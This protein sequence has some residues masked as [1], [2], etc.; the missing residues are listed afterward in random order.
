MTSF[1]HLICDY[2]T[3]DMAWAEMISAMV[4]CLPAGTRL[5]Q[6][7][8]GSFETIATGFVLAQLSLSAPHMRPDNLIMFANCAPRK[9]R[10]DARVN[11]A[12]EGLLFGV[13][14]NGVQ[15]IAVNSGYSL[16]FIRSDLKELWSIAVDDDGSQFRSRDNF[17]KILGLTAKGDF[18][19][20]REQLKP[21]EVIPAEPAEVVGYID[22]FGNMKTTFRSGDPRLAQLAEG[23]RRKVIIGNTVRTAT[24]AT[25]SFN[26]MEGDL[27]FAPGSSGHGQRFWEFFQRGGS[28]YHE[29]GKPGVGAKISIEGLN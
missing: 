11:N 28:A 17:P 1:V 22:S 12:G 26:V 5:H 7:S 25:G 29:F 23:T 18:S 9:D 15:V 14:K 21:E 13:L 19:F 27:A 24:V 4:A 10:R 3:G 8:V 2:A 20:K 16:S 6:T